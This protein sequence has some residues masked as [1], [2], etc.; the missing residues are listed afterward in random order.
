MFIEKAIYGY[1]YTVRDEK[2]YPFKYGELEFRHVSESV[3]LPFLDP[4][5]TILEF[6]HRSIYKAQRG[7]QELSPF[8]REIKINDNIIQW[9]DGD[10]DFVLTINRIT[11]NNG[12]IKA[13]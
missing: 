1:Y 10:Y 8:A 9:E 11:D 5:T 4:G 7:F 6:D 13:K 2:T 3:G 12:K